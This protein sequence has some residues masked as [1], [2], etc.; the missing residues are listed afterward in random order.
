MGRPPFRGAGWRRVEFS[1]AATKSRVLAG[2]RC[3]CIGAGPPDRV[4]AHRSGAFSVVPLRDL[5]PL[6]LRSQDLRPFGCAQGRL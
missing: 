3:E 5:I 6:L 4:A 2:G 1:E